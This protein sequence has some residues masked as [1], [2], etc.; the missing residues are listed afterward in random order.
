M[1]LFIY[2]NSEEACEQ[3]LKAHSDAQAWARSLQLEQ[4]SG[5]GLD[6]EWAQKEGEFEDLAARMA[7]CQASAGEI[8]RRLEI[9]HLKGRQFIRP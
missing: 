6:R 1:I 8:G 2:A 9:L 7:A 5:N 3:S 4:K